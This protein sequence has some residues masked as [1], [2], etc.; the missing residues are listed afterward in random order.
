MRR[1]YLTKPMSSEDPKH[2]ERLREI[3]DES[4]EQYGE[5]FRRLAQGEE[6]KH[7]DKHDEI[8]D[9]EPKTATDKIIKRYG[10]TLEHLADS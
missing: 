3:I 4:H 9:E 5:V 2:S 6:P 10:N 1:R 7:D 8:S